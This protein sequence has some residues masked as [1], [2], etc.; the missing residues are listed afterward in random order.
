MPLFLLLSTA[1]QNYN[2]V[3][4][5]TYQLWLDRWTPHSTSRWVFTVAL[6]IAFTIRVVLKQVIYRFFFFFFSIDVSEIFG[7]INPSRR[8]AMDF[9]SRTHHSL[10]G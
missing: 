4:L 10:S 3:P 8:V 9:T 7:R 1:A 5:Q 6:L 2:L